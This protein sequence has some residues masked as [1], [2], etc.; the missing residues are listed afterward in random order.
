MM[1]NGTVYGL[2]LIYFIL[3]ILLLL[4]K[5]NKPKYNAYVICS[6]K[7]LYR[8]S[9]ALVVLRQLDMFNVNAFDAV[10]PTTK[11]DCKLSMGQYGC[12]L[13]HRTLWKSII[14]RKGNDDEWFFIFEDDIDLPA[15]YKPK[16]IKDLIL[17]ELDRAKKEKADIIYLGHCWGYLCTHAYALNSKAANIM[18]DNTY[19]CRKEK[20]RPIDVQMK[21]VI[22]DYKKIK[23]IYSKNLPNKK[24]CW[25]NGII[26]QFGG[27]TINGPKIKV[28]NAFL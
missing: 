26:H 25:S 1:K 8:K 17:K 2:V 11:G 5:T 9:H 22:V 15:N 13:S 16:Q 18:Y 4:S 6:D 12:I 14:D 21:E 28:K 3:L 19:N 24:S 7:Y 10:Y 27:S 20:P 23:S